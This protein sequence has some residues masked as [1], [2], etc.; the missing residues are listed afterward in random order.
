MRWS[1]YHAGYDRHHI[2]GTHTILYAITDPK[3]LMGSASRVVIVSTPASTSIN[4]GQGRLHRT[5]R[6]KRARPIG[7]PHTGHHAVDRVAVG[8]RSSSD[9]RYLAGN[10]R[11]SWKWRSHFT[12]IASVSITS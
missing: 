1:H 5:P 2:S 6:L 7:A 3:G 11:L 4:R 12:N 9:M 10:S 8:T